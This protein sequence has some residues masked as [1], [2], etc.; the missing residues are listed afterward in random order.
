M[1]KLNKIIGKYQIYSCEWDWGFRR[2]SKSSLGHIIEWQLWLGFIGINK[3]A[4]G[5]Q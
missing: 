3:Y 1:S 4:K 5:Y 2:P